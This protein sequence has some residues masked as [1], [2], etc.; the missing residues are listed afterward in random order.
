MPSTPPPLPEPCTPRFQEY[1]PA[2]VEWAFAADAHGK[3]LRSWWELLRGAEGVPLTERPGFL[4]FVLGLRKA[5]ERA[6]TAAAPVDHTEI[7]GDDTVTD[8]AGCLLK[9]K[10]GV[11]QAVYDNYTNVERL[12][13]GAV[14]D[15]REIVVPIVTADARG[16]PADV[17]R[18]LS[19][20]VLS[21][22]VCRCGRDVE[23]A[24]PAGAGCPTHGFE[25]VS[26]ARILS[27]GTWRDGVEA[28]PKPGMD[29]KCASRIGGDDGSDSTNS[30]GVDDERGQ[31][32]FD[33]A[34]REKRICLV[35]TLRVLAAACR[36]PHTR[37]ELARQSSGGDAGFARG[38][39]LLCDALCGRVSQLRRRER[40]V[41]RRE[42][43]SSGASARG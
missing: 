26:W 32:V 40:G 9:P 13:E 21:A 35:E 33:T 6:G 24:S 16:L 5:C 38:L 37:R 20:A 18:G 15:A 30:C 17:V 19:H 42:L 28:F 3:Q 29:D 41:G 11:V 14:L 43:I 39:A 34:K 22:S 23:L 31:V 2:K 7:N 25:A 36:W 4:P 10:V 1:P 27:S 8:N 12:G